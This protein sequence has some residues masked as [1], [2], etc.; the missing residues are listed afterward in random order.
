M[1]QA[2]VTYQGGRDALAVT[3][4][5]PRIRFQPIAADGFFATLRQRVDAHFKA[6]DRRH[7]GGAFYLAFHFS[8]FHPSS[9]PQPLSCF[10]RP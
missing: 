9:P 1:L 3:A 8:S 7:T 5:A 2:Q 10:S 6:T 4:P